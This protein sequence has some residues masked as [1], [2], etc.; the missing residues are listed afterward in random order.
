MKA[1]SILSVVLYHTQIMSGIKT[2]AYFLCLPAFFFLA[3][4][5]TRTQYTA[6]EFFQHKTLRLMVPYV[7]F[8]ILSWILWM[9]IG[10]NYG[11]DAQQIQAWYLP[12]VGMLRGNVHDLIQNPPLWFLCCLMILEWMYYGIHHIR[13]AAGRY[14]LY[15]ILGG[16]GCIGGAW[17]WRNEWGILS[18]M[19]MLPIYAMGAE[20]ASFLREKI[21]S[22]PTAHLFLIWVAS[23]VGIIGGFLWNKEINISAAQVGNPILFYITII[24]VI[25][26]W[27]SIAVYVE[28]AFREIHSIHFLGCNTLLILCLHI[29]VFGG[30][31]GITLLCGIPLSLYETTIGSLLL[32][33]LS[34]VLLIPVICGINRFLPPIVSGKGKS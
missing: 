13:S 22:I 21:S 25:G 14:V 19:I 11:E 31:K 33:L 17:G 12:L 2:L 7:V 28:R 26:F 10:R 6:G 8:G 4:M 5:F 3:G 27:L 15:I 30:I 1:G 18:A 34:I 32:W 24:A 9:L 20:G 29:L 23:L 16:L